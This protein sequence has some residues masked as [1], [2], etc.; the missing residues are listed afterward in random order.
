[1]KLKGLSLRATHCNSLV[2]IIN[3]EGQTE[4]KPRTARNTEITEL[5]PVLL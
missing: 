5:R 2:L 3:G 1:M 4:E